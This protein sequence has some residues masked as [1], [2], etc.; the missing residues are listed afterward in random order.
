M[1]LLPIVKVGNYRINLLTFNTIEQMTD[2]AVIIDT[3]VE[4]GVTIPAGDEATAFMRYLDGVGEQVSTE[5]DATP[6]TS[7]EDTP[8]T[9]DFQ[10]G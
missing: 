3:G 6:P 8:G 1:P 9:R 7:T 2:G 5:N 10:L 4:G